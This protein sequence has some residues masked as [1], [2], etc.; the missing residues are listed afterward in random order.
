MTG[1]SLVQDRSALRAALSHMR[2]ASPEG[3]SLE[4][5][6]AEE[7][8]WSP[9]FAERVVDEYCGFLYLAA[10]AGFEV[11][12]SQAVDAAWHLHLQWPHYR[13][14]LCRDILGRD[15]EHRPASAD[16]E[17]EIRCAHQYAETLTLYERVFGKPPP[18]D[19]WPDP[20]AQEM[21]DVE[22]EEDLVRT[23]SRRV[24][25]ASLVA[26]LPALAIGFTGAGFFLAGT[27]LIV[28]LVGQAA[29]GAGQSARNRKPG[30]SCGTGGCGGGGSGSSGDDCGASCGG[31]S[32]GGGCGGGGD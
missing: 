4:Q 12:P 17:D 32:C 13:E 29:A 30:S 19:I 9:A 23:L 31:A 21:E 15:L 8:G 3:L 25:L 14:I 1:A 6:L 11:T 28:F 2:I 10:T 5:A 27:A 20:H 7:Q 26:S 22:E 18:A 24:A 16:A